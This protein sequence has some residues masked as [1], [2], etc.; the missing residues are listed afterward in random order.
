[1]GHNV[2]VCGTMGD[3][4]RR[5]ERCD[6]DAAVLDWMLP[7]GDG[8]EL[9][10]ELRTRGFQRP[11]LFL[12]ARSDVLDKVRAFADGCNDFL[13]KPVHMQELVVRIEAHIKNTAHRLVS[14]SIEVH[15]PQ[16]EVLIGGRRLE[17]RL[18]PLELRL[19]V[20][21]LRNPGRVVSRRDLLA[22]V[23]ETPNGRSSNVIGVHL[24]HLRRKLG[25]AGARFETIKGIGYRLSD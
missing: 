6:P 18:T 20:H 2:T 23:F 7:D 5:F 9:C 1:M 17:R 11:I 22:S 8:P 12:T 24:G 21:F 15:W 10:R 4:R 16:M 19:L 13:V 25:A 3:A 14:G